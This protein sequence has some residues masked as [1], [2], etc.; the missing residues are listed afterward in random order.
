MKESN[1]ATLT[2]WR[3]L[4]LEDL[5]CWI[6][7]NNKLV[8]KNA[9]DQLIQKIDDSW[10]AKLRWM[11]VKNIYATHNK[12]KTVKKVLSRVLLRLESDPE[13]WG[14]NLGSGFS[15][16]HA[17]L[18]NIDVMNAEN[19][20][21]VTDGSFI[22]IRDSVLDVVVAQE[23]LEHIADFQFTINELNRILKPSGLLYVQ[24]PFQIGK[25]HGP[26]DYW[27][28]SRDALE[29]LFE[30]NAWKLEE[31]GMV[32][33]HGTGF[34]RILVEFIAV[35]S[36]TLFTRLYLPAK[37]LAAIMFIPLRLLDGLTKFSSERDRIAA[38]YYVV[39]SKR[40]D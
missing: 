13:T 28:F 24:T 36:S 11:I 29:Y 9:E 33:G 27:R 3:H 18:L 31:I 8:H 5:D 21:I 38:G 20:N 40:G 30:N 17:R 14:L 6:W 2:P 19:V 1:N 16:P 7:R 12:S 15:A 37:T 34:Y 23:V 35:T 39:A 25:H 26:Q 32:H 22:P 4:I 10:W